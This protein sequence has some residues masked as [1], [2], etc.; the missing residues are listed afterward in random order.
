MQWS[1]SGRILSCVEEA[2]KSRRSQDVPDSPPVPLL[3]PHGQCY[4]LHL[5]DSTSESRAVQRRGS[6]LPGVR[7]E[8]PR[9]CGGLRPGREVL[10]LQLPQVGAQPPGPHP[11]LPLQLG[12]LRHQQP[13]VLRVPLP[14]GLRAQNCSLD[15][16]PALGGPHGAPQG[17]AVNNYI[18]IP[19]SKCGHRCA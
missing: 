12:G 17:D 14:L 9:L 15:Q 4:L 16:V 6:Q 13:D 11:L 18:E 1:N 3:S 8:P 5:L 19:C 7:V 2:S 10:S